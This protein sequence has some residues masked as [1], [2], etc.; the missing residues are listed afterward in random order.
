MTVTTGTSRSFTRPP[1]WAGMVVA[2]PSNEYPASGY[3]N[4][5]LFFSRSMYLM[6]RM[7][8]MSVTNFWVGIHPSH[9]IRDSFPIMASVVA[10]TEK[11]RG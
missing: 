3:I 2:V 1:S 11:R 8:L 7:R 6:S 5:L 4:T 9:R 10:T